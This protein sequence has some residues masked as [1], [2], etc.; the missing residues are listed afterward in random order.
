MAEHSEDL[1]EQSLVLDPALGFERTRTDQVAPVGEPV[2][3]RLAA[4]PDDVMVV[5]CQCEGGD[6]RINTC[7]PR[8]VLL[9]VDLIGVGIKPTVA[10]VV[11]LLRGIGVALAH[12]CQDPEKGRIDL[13]S[14]VPDDVVSGR[15]VV[16]RRSP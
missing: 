11:A 9:G 8:L 3:P 6:C 10:P 16:R 12:R 14:H 13:P 2:E 7:R 1:V 15:Q 5:R 4:P